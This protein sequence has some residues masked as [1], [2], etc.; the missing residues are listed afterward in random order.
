[1][2][3]EITTNMKVSNV[4]IKRFEQFRYLG[5]AVTV[6]GAAL[7]DLQARIKKANGIF[8]EMCPLWRN[9]DIDY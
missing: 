1:M 6:D 2:N 8:V 3:S 5:G 7:Q 9:N 4:V